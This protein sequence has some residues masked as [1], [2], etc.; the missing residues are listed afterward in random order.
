M[1]FLCTVW[2][3]IKTNIVQSFIFERGWTAVVPLS[4]AYTCAESINYAYYMCI[5]IMY[6]LT[7][8]SLSGSFSDIYRRWLIHTARAVTGRRLKYQVNGY[9]NY[10][11]RYKLLYYTDV[12]YTYIYYKYIVC[13]HNRHIYY[14]Y[15]IVRVRVY[16]QKP[17][18]HLVNMCVPRGRQLLLC[19]CYCWR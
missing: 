17:C 6:V 14:I 10:I 9:V 15:Y 13:T 19:Y 2:E 12:L 11:V 18:S 4:L 8:S 3:N 1:C 7:Q 5:R 16:V